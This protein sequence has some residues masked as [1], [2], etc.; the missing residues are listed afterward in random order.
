V[1]AITK[2]ILNLMPMCFWRVG[3][4]N[5]QRLVLCAHGDGTLNPFLASRAWRL[6]LSTKL[7]V[8]FINDANF[9]F[10]YSLILASRA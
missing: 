7:A 6:S 9:L 1:D 10:I 2:S 8:E 3:F 4:L 5:N